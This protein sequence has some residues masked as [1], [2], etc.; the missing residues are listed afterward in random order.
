[1]LTD[2]I[3]QTSDW[4]VDESLR[5]TRADR[6]MKHLCEQM[7][8]GGIPITRVHIACGQLHPLFKAF[9]VVWSRDDGLVRDRFSYHGASTDAWQ[10]SPLKAVLNVNRP[11]IRA[12]IFKGEGLEE[13]PVIREFKERGLTDYL[14]MRAGFSEPLDRALDE[15]DGCIASFSTDAEGG[16]SDACVQTI[17][18]LFPR[19]AVALKT[20]VRETTAQNLASTYLGSQ[21]GERV[22][23]GHIRRG[24]C[25]TIRAA[26][27]YSDMRDSTVTADKMDPRIFLERLNRYFECTAGSVLDHGGEVLRFIGDAVLAIF[28]INGP[29]GAERA[30]RMAVSA[31]RDTIRRLEE[32]NAEPP[33]HDRDPI[34]FG[35][36]LHVGDVLY[37]NIG[38]AERLEFSVIGPTA[39]EVARLEDLTKPLDRP[40]LASD[41]FIALAH[42]DWEAMGSHRLRGVTEPQPIYALNV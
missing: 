4:L 22:L 15:L 26:V 38:V 33:P 9:S 37:G 20:L 24:D 41:A 5:G 34:R 36:G 13:F 32:L 6:L 14:C 35:L 21:A 27:W 18:R 42:A 28:P 31:A 40:I 25:D 17:K 11:E 30:G 8:A 10:Q 12:R 1:M 29:G 3:Q 7:V 16:F 19:L 2:W 39:N 23:R